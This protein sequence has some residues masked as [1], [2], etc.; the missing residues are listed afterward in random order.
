MTKC[1]VRTLGFAVGHCPRFL[2]NDPQKVY[3]IFHCSIAA[4]C[5]RIIFQN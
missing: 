2:Y 1:D 4:S 3:D 5:V